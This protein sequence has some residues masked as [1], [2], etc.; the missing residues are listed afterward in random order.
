MAK[1]IIPFGRIIKQI[2]VPYKVR[3]QT[4]LP[5]KAIA[6]AFF[7]FCSLCCSFLVSWCEVIYAPNSKCRPSSHMP[8]KKTRKFSNFRGDECVEKLTSLITFFFLAHRTRGTLE[9]KFSKISKCGKWKWNWIC[10]SFWTDKMDNVAKKRSN[11]P[12][13]TEL[14]ACQHAPKCCK[15]L[16]KKAESQRKSSAHA[17]TTT[18]HPPS[19]QRLPLATP[20][21]GK[22][23]HWEKPVWPAGGVF[24]PRGGEGGGAQNKNQMAVFAE[25]SARAADAGRELF[26]FSCNFRSFKLE[27]VRMRARCKSSGLALCKWHLLH[28]PKLKRILGKSIQIT[29]LNITEFCTDFSFEPQLYYNLVYFTLT[30]RTCTVPFW[31][32]TICRQAFAD[33]AFEKLWLIYPVNICPERK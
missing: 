23:V 8:Q 7:F 10:C 18:H 6:F 27:E 15:R 2:S 9:Q 20:Y 29:W 17:P 21:S 11:R 5:L 33:A 31:M 12:S 25:K 22:K 13:R 30:L 4:E 3:M 14:F 19:I 32:V 28:A 1:L 24:I 16:S 26:R